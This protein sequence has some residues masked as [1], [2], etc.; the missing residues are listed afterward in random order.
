[1]RKLALGVHASGSPAIM[2]TDLNS[3]FEFLVSSF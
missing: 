3:S 2:F 1:M